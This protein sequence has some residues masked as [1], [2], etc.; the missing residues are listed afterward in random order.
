VSPTSIGTV[1]SA[2]VF[3]PAGAGTA[4]I[5]ATSTQDSTKSGNATVTVT[6]TIVAP[7]NLVY[8][9]TTISASVGQ[10][11]T[12]DTPTV[13]GT[14][15]S[16]SVSPALP[17]G[18]SLNTSTGTISGT[19]TAT[20]AQTAYTVT[21]TNGTG[22]TTAT[23]QISVIL[24]VAPSNLAYM[25]IW[26][27]VGQT[28]PPDIPTVTGT[29]SSYSIYPQL[30]SGLSLN[31]S[32]G[33]ISGTPTIAD[34]LW[35]SWTVTA[36]N[37]AGSTTA[38][39]LILV[40][41][42]PSS[43]VYTQNPIS[44]SVGLAITPDIPNLTG[45]FSS[46]SISPALP[47]GL[48]LN[49]STGTISGTPTTTAAQKAYT[50]TATNSGGNI[51]TGVTITVNQVPNILLELGHASYIQAIRFEG[52]SVLSADRTGHWVLWNYTSGALLASGD[53]TQPNGISGGGLVANP[54][55]MA[56]QTVV[57]GVANGLEIRAQSDGHLL[58]MIAFS[59]LNILPSTNGAWWKLAPDG[60][61]IC[62]GSNTGLFVYSLAGQIV[63]SESGDYA[64][65]NIFAAPGQVLVALGPAGQNVIESIST[66]GG[67]STVSPVFS[68]QFNSWFV[69]GARFLTN[70]STTVW[71]YSN[72]GVQQA[73]V[74]LP[75]ITGLTGL[76]NW[77]WTY[78]ST[79]PS[80]VDIYPIGSETPALSFNASGYPNIIASGTTIGFISNDAGQ[81]SVIDLS[82]SNP[83]ETDYTVP[84][85]SLTTFAASSSSQWIVGNEHGALLDG[86][87]LSSTPR[88]FGQGAAWSIAGSS[89]SV[90]ISTANG[91]IS[92]FDSYQSTLEETINFSSGKLA[93]SSDGTVLGASANANDA[94][95]E[96]DR[97]LNF[98]SLPS[99]NVISSFPYNYN[100]SPTLYDFTLATS[101]STIGQVTGTL[102]T[103]N[104]WTLLRQVTPISGGTVIWSDTLSMADYISE[105]IL[106]SPD[107]TLVAVYNVA[108]SYS[109]ATSIFKN[110]TLVTVVLG[111]AVGWIDNNRILVNQY[112]LAGSGANQGSVYGGCTIYSSAGVQLATPSLPELMSIQTVNSDNVY[113]P[114]YN[115]IFSLTTGQPFWTAS[116]PRSGVGAVSGAYVVYESGH[117]V[118]VESF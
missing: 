100:V 105:P 87:S 26:A 7:S 95:A 15:S 72:T 24:V 68:G 2:G 8:P 89:S 74:V 101:G 47:A 78:D 36:I 71:V 98:Y 21:A 57:D 99:G 77:I 4:T 34:P 80:P 37:P 41:L 69:D 39:L 64:L 16:Y 14:V 48:S 82:G 107:G 23:L 70:L 111:A 117:S 58:S 6:V 49:T 1:S 104:G 66:V 32:T 50:V 13:T 110:G 108:G 46:Y 86:A 79:Y 53:G 73:I 29:L 90:A 55:D 22:F 112:V 30:P 92:V 97:T 31:P 3:T 12:P 113:D 61:Y 116:F 96:P 93:L 38:P 43:L 81:V 109:S 35:G 27:S 5:T 54:I 60:S 28:I 115:A 42:P 85:A 25:A 102:Q 33:T 9:Q 114:S 91:I 56:G 62:I 76:G 17:S 20:A 19:P 45:T 103:I 44:A 65:V 52:G 84:I 106:L 10:A 51:T 18:L 11:I 88:Y 94:G 118:V 67:T 40:T 83:S 75:S 63:A 59:G